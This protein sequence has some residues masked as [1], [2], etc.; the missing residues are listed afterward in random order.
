M[1]INNY[2]SSTRK[3]TFEESPFNEVDSLILS[4]LSYMNLDLVVPSI[5]YP[6]NYKTKIKELDL[7]NLSALAFGSVD[8][9]RN[10]KMLNLMR[11][12]LRYQDI[13]VCYSNR[14]FDEETAN[15]FFAITF[16]LPNGDAYIAYRGTD[17]TAVGWKEDFLMTFKSS[18]LSQKEALEYFKCI[19]KYF[20]GKFYIGGHSKGGNLAMYVTLHMNKK[21]EDRLIASYSF[22][23]PG[24]KDGVDTSSNGYQ[25]IVNKGY[26]Y[27]TY[28]DLIGIVF[29]AYEN[30]IIVDSSGIVLGGHDPFFWQVDI[31]NHCFKKEEERSSLSKKSEEAFV[32][33]ITSIDDNDK[34]LAV[35][36]FFKIFHRVHTIYDLLKYGVPSIAMRN[37]VLKEYSDEQQERIKGII[38]KLISY[39]KKAF[40]PKREKKIKKS[41]I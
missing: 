28:N 40:F 7:T 29:N 10:K 30:P 18:I 31:K 21:Y 19:M 3:I 11:K 41:R 15:Q 23:G 9:K 5:N 36:A 37:K 1:N 12:S 39:I 8:A 35:E 16:I 27:V 14:I 32:N 34:S 33:W 13:E 26:K 2:I 17:I 4:E 20:D 6:H 25:R 24:F 38:D 22:D